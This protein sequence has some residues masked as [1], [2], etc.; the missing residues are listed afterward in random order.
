MLNYI[1]PA[2][3]F[4]FLLVFF[5]LAVHS[6]HFTSQTWFAYIWEFQVHSL[7]QNLSNAWTFLSGLQSFHL[8]QLSVTHACVYLFFERDLFS[9]TSF[10][11]A[12]LI[13]SLLY[14]NIVWV[15]FVRRMVMISVQGGE[16]TQTKAN[17]SAR[18]SDWLLL[19][20][21]APFCFQ[22]VMNQSLNFWLGLA[23][24]PSMLRSCAWLS[25]L[26]MLQSG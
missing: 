2:V 24:C 6:Q 8:T 18:S 9:E 12:A 1:L 26:S 3:C 16:K 19:P 21:K 10:I 15:A 5:F 20:G 7:I 11:H 14:E 17:K 13:S 23:R 22:G 4:F 25:W